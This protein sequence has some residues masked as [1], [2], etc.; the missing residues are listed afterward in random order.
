MMT[1]RPRVVAFEGERGH[2]IQDLFGG[3]GGWGNV[4]LRGFP[5][6]PEVRLK[7]KSKYWGSNCEGRC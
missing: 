3:G 1:G 5:E 6:R 7:D 4:E 2:Q